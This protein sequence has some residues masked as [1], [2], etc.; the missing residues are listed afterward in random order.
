VIEAVETIAG[1]FHPASALDFLPTSQL[2]EL[3]LERLRA[4]T[5]RAW[6]SVPLM[7]A[8]M[9]DRDVSPISDGNTDREIMVI[10]VEVPDRPG[11]LAGVLETFEGSD[12]NI[13]YTY[14]FPFARG[15]KAVLIFR[16]DQ[17]D[18]AISLLQKTGINV[19]ES[20]G[21]YGN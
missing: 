7:R 16:F 19:I 3:Q 6:H 9:D 18:A 13:E 8:R 20:V 2:R 10:A 17:P 4:V 14:A 15:D 12:I 1:T 5:R 11:G 21:V